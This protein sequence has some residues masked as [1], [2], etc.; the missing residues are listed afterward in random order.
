VN[1]RTRDALVLLR[2]FIR[3]L[4]IA[5]GF[6]PQSGEGVEELGWWR[7]WGLAEF[8]QSHLALASTNNSGF[9]EGRCGKFFGHGNGKY[10]NPSFSNSM[11]VPR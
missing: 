6:P 10:T 2:R 3:R 9:V 1:P 5:L 11:L 4:P 7:A 8:V